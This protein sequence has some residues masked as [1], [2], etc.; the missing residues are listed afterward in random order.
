MNPTVFVLDDDPAIRRSF[1]ELAKTAGLQV[2]AYGS[3]DR[4]LASYDVERPGCLVLDL[5]LG[6]RRSGLDVQDELK[7][8][9]ATLPIII[10]TGFG[11]VPTSVRALKSGALDY[12]QKPA[13]PRLLLERIREAIEVDLRSRSMPN[14]RAA[15]RRRLERLTPREREV[16]DLLLDGKTSKEIATSLNMSP[17]TVEGHRRK[18]LFKMEVSS[19]ALLM[20]DLLESGSPKERILRPRS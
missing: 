20:R 8:R 11:D 6:G 5:R 7:R 17:R 2:E 12:L 13:A 15:V 10:L 16:A 1:Q 3:G 14:G 18:I 4:F 19:S 9:G